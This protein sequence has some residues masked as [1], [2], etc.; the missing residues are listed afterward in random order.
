MRSQAFRQLAA[1]LVI[2]FIAG[3]PVQAGPV[4]I[5]EVVQVL[6]NYRNPPELRLR[7]TQDP[8]GRVIVDTRPVSNITQRG[9]KSASPAGDSLLAGI[10]DTA[11]EQQGGVDIV[12]EGDVE[13]VICDCGEFG[14]LSEKFL[15]W[16]L[17]F[18]A[19]IPVFFIDKD[20]SPP[21]PFASTPTPTPVATPTPTPPPI[22]EPTTLLLLGSG[23][24]A[25]G[26]GLRR[27]QKN[28]A[29]TLDQSK[30]EG[31]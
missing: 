10:A 11:T 9:D 15:A 24:A 16:P 12:A 17:V 7:N 13:G 23:L 31:Q 21:P 19:G 18:L 25:F 4:V 26:I 14:V 8:S 22:P 6:G 28:G 27:R 5:S 3:T 30:E 29:A 2:L 20:G 1:I